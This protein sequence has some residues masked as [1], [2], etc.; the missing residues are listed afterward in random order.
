MIDR[1]LVN[2]IRLPYSTPELHVRPTVD[3]NDIAHALASLAVERTTGADTTLRLFVAGKR[4]TGP[5]YAQLFP[6]DL[7]MALY[8]LGDDVKPEKWRDVLEFCCLTQGKSTDPVTGEEK[9]KIIHQD[10]SPFNEHNGLSYRFSATDTTPFMLVGFGEYVR[11]TGD[12]DFVKMHEKEIEY[13]YDWLKR[14]TRHG[15][16]WDDPTLYGA[17]QSAALAGYFR[18]GGFHEVPVHFLEYP[19]TYANVNALSVAALRSLASFRRQNLLPH[20]P[21][22][23]ELDTEADRTARALSRQLWLPGKSTLGAAMHGDGRVLQTRYADPVWS[24]YFLEERDFSVSQWN[25]MF[26]TIE[27]LSTP[28]GIANHEPM[29]GYEERDTSHMAQVEQVVWPIET[30]FSIMLA[31]KH[32]RHDIVENNL[33]VYDFLSTQATPFKEAIPLVEEE[34]MM[35]GCDLQLWTVATMSRCLRMKPPM[36]LSAA[37]QTAGI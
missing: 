33:G 22:A 18:D 25:G 14:H 35:F 20:L 36:A 11:L 8:A 4:D 21:C 34:P 5:D 30:A 32:G 10:P 37:P 29:L 9:G 17:T 31:D 19:A 12:V 27:S 24:S 1:D 13:A 6:R 3:G 26:E 16:V 15:L 23:R 2:T 28:W 7:L